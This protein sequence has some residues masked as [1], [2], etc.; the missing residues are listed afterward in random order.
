MSKYQ[1][2]IDA[3]FM[4][5]VEADSADDAQQQVEDDFDPGDGYSHTTETLVFEADGVTIAE[6]GDDDLQDCQEG[7]TGGNA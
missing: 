7:L 4:F 6:D 3:C 2:R 1:V 5:D